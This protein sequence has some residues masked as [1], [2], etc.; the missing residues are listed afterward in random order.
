M[1]LINGYKQDR[2]QQAIGQR[3]LVMVV[4]PPPELSTVSQFVIGAYPAT[5]GC[6]SAVHD[7]L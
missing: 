2:W 6:L 5:T 1:F 4:L 7:F 3:S